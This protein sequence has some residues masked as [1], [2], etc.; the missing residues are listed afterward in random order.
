MCFQRLFYTFNYLNAELNPIC[1]LLAY[2][3][4]TIFSTLAGK[5][6]ISGISLSSW[7]QIDILH[8]KW[9][10]CW[11]WIYWYKLIMN[12]EPLKHDT[13]HR[14]RQLMKETSNNV[15]YTVLHSS[16]F[17]IK[18]L[19]WFLTDVGKYVEDTTHMQEVQHKP[20]C[21]IPLKRTISSNPMDISE[22]LKSCTRLNEL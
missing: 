11:C 7:Y 13:L 22:I 17:A 8:W 10:L 9:F 3:E 6:L 12:D 5:Q 14:K 1:H 15:V 18:N 21:G 16:A 4:L 2:S 19:W 20:V